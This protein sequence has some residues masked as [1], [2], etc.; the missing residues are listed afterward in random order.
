MDDPADA[1]VHFIHQE[2]SKL[3]EDLE[4]MGSTMVVRYGKPA[5]KWK[6]VIKEF[7]VETVYTNRDYEPYALER[8]ST[9]C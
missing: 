7:E 4:D 5:E 8:G 3:Q 1:R 2:V 6:E 9:S